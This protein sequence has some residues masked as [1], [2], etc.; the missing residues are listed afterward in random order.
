M[1]L[2]ITAIYVGIACAL[3]VYFWNIGLVLFCKIYGVLYE[4]VSLGM[5]KKLRLHA[6]RSGKTIVQ[7]NGVPLG[8][9]VKIA[10]LE[11]VDYP[12]DNTPKTPLPH[13]LSSK[14]ASKRFVVLNGGNIFMVFT[15]LVTYLIWTGTSNGTV[16]LDSIVELLVQ[17]WQA[18][19]GTISY[20]EL[21]TTWDS[22]TAG[23]MLFWGCLFFMTFLMILVNFANVIGSFLQTL[24]FGGKRLIKAVL[25]LF[26]F[27][28]LGLLIWI[29]YS[30]FSALGGGFGNITLLVLTSVVTLFFCFIVLHFFTMLFIPSNKTK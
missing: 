11:N 23:N 6:Y 5:V 1:E 14:S 13:E 15:L 29:D 10:G 25:N 17:H 28:F 16:T 7:L 3:C 9:F 24:Q 19:R 18:F 2:S 8:G 21:Q 12:T 26:L 4:E 22:L 20:N 27:S 30:H